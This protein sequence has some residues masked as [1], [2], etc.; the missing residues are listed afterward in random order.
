MWFSINVNPGCE[1][2]A[3]SALLADARN[4]GIDDAFAPMSE[5][6]GAQENAVV[7]MIPGCV[8]LVSPGVREARAAVR[9]ARGLGSFLP[10]EGAGVAALT[11]REAQV[12]E[13]LVGGGGRRVAAFSEGR[14][15]EGGG[16]AVDSGALRGRE[17]LI[18]H[19][20]CRRKRAFVPVT[21]AGREACAELGLRVTRNARG[22]NTAVAN[23]GT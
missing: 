6:R 14:M 2:E 9:R 11:E 1:V 22:T 20:S 12:I 13:G 4:L 8:V 23:M 19:V 7:P 21:L 17:D 3:A 5:V 18:G 15:L 16:V 10:R